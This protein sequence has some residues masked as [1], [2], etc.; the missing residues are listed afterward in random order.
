MN[1]HPHLLHT[2]HCLAAMRRL[3]LARN[4]HARTT[5]KIA[6]NDPDHREQEADR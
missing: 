6:V 3:A 4:R 2:R 5:T 1:H